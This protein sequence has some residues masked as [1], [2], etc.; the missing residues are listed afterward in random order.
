MFVTSSWLLYRKII[1]FSH[2]LLHNRDYFWLDQRPFYDSP[3]LHD[4]RYE[5]LVMLAFGHILELFIP[6][7]L[8]ILVLEPHG[9]F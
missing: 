1:N 5:T 3:T 2:R 7:R 8:D 9:V 6:N 4:F